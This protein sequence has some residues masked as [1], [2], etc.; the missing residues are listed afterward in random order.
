MKDT[1]ELGGDLRADLD[2]RLD[3]ADRSGRAVAVA[4]PEERDQAR[5]HR[6]LVREL[7]DRR[8]GIG[9][10]HGEARDERAADTCADEARFFSNRRAFKRGEPDFGRLLSAIALD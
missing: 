4:V 3:E 8:A 2:R 5:L 6:H 9:G 10:V 1:V 7:D